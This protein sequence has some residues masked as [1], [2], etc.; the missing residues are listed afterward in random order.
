MNKLFLLLCVLAASPALGQSNPGFLD[1]PSSAPGAHPARASNL[2]AGFSG[3]L[4]IQSGAVDATHTTATGGTSSNYLGLT[5]GTADCPTSTQLSTSVLCIR[6]ATGATPRQNYTVNVNLDSYIGAT[7]DP[8]ALYAGVRVHNGA[9]QS[10][11]LNTVTHLEPGAGGG[12]GYEV[13]VNNWSCDAGTNGLAASPGCTMSGPVG[14][15]ITGSSP[16]PSSAAINISGASTA[17]AQWH[18]GIEMLGG[19]IIDRYSIY[20]NNASQIDYELAGYH[21]I[22]IDLSAASFSQAAIRFATSQGVTWLGTLANHTIYGAGTSMV[23]TNSNGPQL[24]LNDTGGAKLGNDEIGPK[25]TLFGTGTAATAY[26]IG[27]N[28]SELTAFTGGAFTVRS[29]ATGAGMAGVPMMSLSASGSL[30]VNGLSLADGKL[31]CWPTASG[32]NTIACVTHQMSGST[33]KFLFFSGNSAS[34]VGMA[35]IDDATGN[36]ILKGTLTQNGS[37]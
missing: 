31:M 22:G 16:Y 7:P 24:V 15:L 6:A 18:D 20:N 1:L 2:N 21:F 28:P 10:W 23:L 25:L 37:P 14:L 8:V 35:S 34:I 27:I 32:T 30:S 36:M 26:G 5:P 29:S 3:K 9:P 13:D 19:S 33:G 11:A 12:I 17:N 4:D